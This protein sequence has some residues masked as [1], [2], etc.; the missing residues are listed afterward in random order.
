MMFSKLVRRQWAAV[1]SCLSSSCLLHPLSL[2]VA[3]VWLQLLVYP[4]S[5]SDAVHMIHGGHGPEPIHVVGF[6]LEL[7]LPAVVLGLMHTAFCFS[8]NILSYIPYTNAMTVLV[9]ATGRC[10][11]K[12]VVKF[13]HPHMELNASEG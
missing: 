7:P 8:L 10:C 2:M 3:S 5:S 12:L 4:H 9:V 11:V 13:T 1:S 6:I